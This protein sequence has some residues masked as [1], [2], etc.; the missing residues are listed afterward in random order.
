M[1]QKTP[2]LFHT[3]KT[4]SPL[5]SGAPTEEASYSWASN[6]S[7]FLPGQCAKHGHFRGLKTILYLHEGLFSSVNQGVTAQVVVS[8]KGFAAPFMVTNKRPLAERK[9]KKSINSAQISNSGII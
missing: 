7:I 3:F 6:Q 1:T 4:Q 2:T 8:D 5:V 9:E